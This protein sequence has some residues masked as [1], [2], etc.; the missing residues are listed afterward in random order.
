MNKHN[1]IHNLK[2]AV[3]ILAIDFDLTNREVNE[4]V[5][6]GKRKF[7]ILVYFSKMLLDNA[8]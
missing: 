5:S 2:Q 6:S 1:P 7:Y 3:E 8:G 4:Q